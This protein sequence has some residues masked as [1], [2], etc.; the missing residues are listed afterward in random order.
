MFV[1]QDRNRLL[2][3]GVEDSSNIE[4]ALVDMVTLLVVHSRASKP[5]PPGRGHHA[6]R[7]EDQR[8]SPRGSGPGRR[9]AAERPSPS[10]GP[11]AAGQE[12]LPLEFHHV[13]GRQFSVVLDSPTSWAASSPRPTARRLHPGR[14]GRLRGRH[15]SCSSRSV[16]VHHRRP[17]PGGTTRP[18]SAP[19]SPP[20]AS[21]TCSATPSSSRGIRGPRRPGSSPGA[22][23]P[24]AETCC[25]WPSATRSPR[26]RNDGGGRVARVP[27]AP[28]ARPAACAGPGSRL[29]TLG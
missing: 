8:G 17:S 12:A 16:G 11:R 27:P 3:G 24:G 9:H 23:T 1:H 26:R 14:G 28:R 4:S 20:A 10:G 29:E 2:S 21:S 15:R 19:V 25:T 18:S 5:T 6:R 22:S 7:R 13:L